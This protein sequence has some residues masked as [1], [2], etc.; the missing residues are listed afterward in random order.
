MTASS[1]APHLFEPN[2]NMASLSEKTGDLQTA[3]I[4]VQA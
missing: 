1:L 2:Y 3:Y 4:V